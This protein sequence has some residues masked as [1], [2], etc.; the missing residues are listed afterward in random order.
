[1]VLFTR[2][3]SARA[4]RVGTRQRPSGQQTR[5]RFTAAVLNY[6][7]CQ[8][9][10]PH[11]KIVV[12][13]HVRS[14]RHHPAHSILHICTVIYLLPHF[15]NN[16]NTFLTTY[17]L[18]KEDE[19]PEGAVNLETV[20]TSKFTGRSAY[21]QHKSDVKVLA[22]TDSLKTQ[23]SLIRPARK[24]RTCEND[25]HLQYLIEFLPRLCPRLHTFRPDLVGSQ[26]D[27]F[28]GLVDEK[29][30]GEGLQSWHEA[31]A[32][33]TADSWALRCTAE[34]PA[35]STGS[36]A[37]LPF[38]IVR[39]PGPQLSSGS[40][41]SGRAFSCSS[42]ISLLHRSSF[43]MIRLRHNVSARPWGKMCNETKDA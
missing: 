7:H 27:L 5:G 34:L 33:W 35:L 41:N 24:G 8:L 19:V 31:K 6:L 18:Q 30:V 42:Q 2:N 43:V 16:E 22:K 21:S 17:P 25:F 20:E 28:Y 40:P 37:C 3:A 26:V 15:F 38:W 39:H 14:S 29:R 4:C 9:A 32:K 23:K 10:V 1:M 13:T 36:S 12:P 11:V